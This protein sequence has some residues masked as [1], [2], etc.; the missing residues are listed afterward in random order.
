MFS[1]SQELIPISF[2]KCTVFCTDSLHAKQE[3]KQLDFGHSTLK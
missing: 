3:M 1:I 2:L